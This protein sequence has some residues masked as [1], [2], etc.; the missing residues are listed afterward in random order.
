[1][2]IIVILIIAAVILYLFLRESKH[3]QTKDQDPHKSSAI[4]AF[5]GDFT[6]QSL[7]FI[8]RGKLFM[9]DGE[10]DVQELQS[11]Y[12]QSVMDRMQ[13]SRQRHSWKEGTA[14]ES[15]YIS[16]RSNVPSDQHMLIAKA[17][18][19]I[20]NGKLLYFLSDNRVG[21]LFEYNFDTGEEK[22]LIH[23]QQ[24]LLEDFSIDRSCQS[25]VCS[26][27]SN[28]G[29]ANI[30]QM[31]MDGSNYRELSGGDTVDSAPTW[32][33]DDPD[34]ILFQSSGVARNEE[35]YVVAL[36]PAS[37]Q[38]LDIQKRE[39]TTVR[40]EENYD[41]LQPKVC[42]SGDLLFIQR[43]YEPPRYGS[44]KFLMDF[45]LFPFRLL[46]AVFHYLNFFS[47]MYTRKP[48][49]SAGGPEVQ[50]DLKEL[51]IKGKRINAENALKKEN[52]VNGVRSLVPKSWQ[53]VRRTRTGN[54]QVLAT[55]VASY[56]I[57]TDG[58]IIFTNGY[59]VFLLDSSNN[60]QVVFRGK[61]IAE[62]V[63]R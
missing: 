54:E 20:P 11:P 5:S 61:L 44:R 46:R 8:A 62:L 18:Q 35:G 59:G 38:M 51:L 9:K 58:K 39:L 57:T 14:F 32:I 63:V 50:A 1:M 33:P 27:K 53:L 31:D 49:T 17:A 6:K 37:I 34:R 4:N 3:D 21:G 48:L 55:N 47:L 40:E 56:D 13:R 22:R 29:T 45:L 19:F 26:Q 16:N 30:V 42:P 52:P 28:N 15:S 23:Q 10:N 24:L 12:V 43:P 7:V 41:F 36:G 60:A 25:L 2:H